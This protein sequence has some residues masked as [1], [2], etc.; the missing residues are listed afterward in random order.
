M[1]NRTVLVTGATGFI[2]QHI[3]D[4]LLSKGYSVIGTARSQS[5]YQPILDAFKEK[6]PDAKLS[7]EIVPDISLEDA[8]DDVL[9][10]HP[11]ITAVLHT[12]S[13][14]SFGLNKD[15][16]EAYLNPAVNGTLNI[17]K[18][19]EKY[20]PQVTNVVT[21]SSYVAIMTGMPSHLHTSD[22]WNPINWEN[23]VNNE[24]FAY[25]ASKTYA[26]RAARDFAKEHN[27]NFK[28]STVNPPLVFGPQLFDFSVGP[29]LN[30]SNQM[31]TAATTIDKDST[32]AELG[33]PALAADVRDIAAFHVL[34]LENEK[35]ADQRLFIAAGPVVTQTILNIINENIPELKGKVALG[36]PASEKELIEKH[37]DKYDLTNLYNVIGKYEFIPIEKSVVDVLEQY[38]RFNKVN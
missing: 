9:K 30:T 27:V 6:Y 19:I 17:L 23:D 24:Y 15:L 16:K 33:T 26:E 38:L 11:E 2:A 22:T 37:T 7:F 25:I 35:A 29:V 34:P 28:L 14:F 3:I 13:P 21:T 12:A 32:K 4:D 20:A 5:K 10:K 8:F 1:A 36:D 18:A 31:I